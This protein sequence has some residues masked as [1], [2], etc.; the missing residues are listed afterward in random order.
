MRVYLD[1]NA[2][3]PLRPEARDAMLPFLRHERGNPSSAHAL[4]RRERVAV[5][6]ARGEIAS[7]L[8]VRTSEVIF[9]S[10]GTESNV[11]AILGVAWAS[12]KRTVL[13]TP[14]EHSS[15]LRP[16]E[17]LARWGFHVR[18][19]P[20]DAQ[21]RVSP[22]DLRR[23]LSNDTALVSI[24]WANNEIGV[25]QP[26]EELA[27]VCR[28][29]GVPFHSDAVQAIGRIP[30]DGNVADLLS[31]SAHKFG[32]PTGVGFLVVRQGVPLVPVL[33]GGGQERGLRSGTEN[34]AG[35][36]GC[37]AALR[38]AINEL[39]SAAA[40]CQLLRER[41][42]AA[43][44]DLPGVVRYSGLGPDFLPNTLCLGFEGIPG[45]VLVARLDLEGVCVSVGSACASG[46]AD[47]SHVLLAL[48]VDPE[49][50]RSAIRFSLGAENTVEEIDRAAE[51]VRTVIRACRHRSGARS[52]QWKVA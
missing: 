37:A 38:A 8:G 20:V 26:A 13:T 24:G 27:R 42:W 35:I 52:Q 36:V 50:A 11:L 23:A 29:Q 17:C 10:G 22:A 16:V 46:A 1:H 47:P 5:E 39:A 32:G 6:E 44:Q 31:V 51:I 4:G 40:H 45:D 34:V 28:E 21:G 30:V 2:T 3:S 14:L 33:L 18:Y 25:C 9:T 49:A 19:L 15:V 41:L 7:L 12:T 48:G 43:L